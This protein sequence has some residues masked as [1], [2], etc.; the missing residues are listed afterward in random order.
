LDN[1]ATTRVADE[2][3]DAMHPFLTSLYGNPSSLHAF[4]AGVAKSIKKAR[5]QVAALLGV[6]DPS[7]IT[8]TSGGTEGDNLAIRGILEANPTKK[9]IVVTPVEH[10]AVLSLAAV[11]KKRGY[12]ITEVGVDSEGMLDLEELRG[13]IRPDTALVSVMYANNETGVIFPIKEVGEIVREKRSLLHVDAVQA[14]GKIPLDV[15]KIPVDL[16]VISGHKFHAPKGVGALF[17]RRGTRIH[18]QIIG[19]HQEKNRRGGT[20]NV[21]SIV[22]MGKAS[23]L[24]LAAL[25]EA[26]RVRGLR[27]RLE[28]GILKQCSTARLNGGR[29]LRLPNTLNIGFEGFEGE[30]LA[31]LLDHYG[32]CV[33]TGSACTSGSVDPS[34]VLR[35]M[36]LPPPL[37]QGAI[38]F[39]LSRYTTEAEIAYTLEKIPQA[40]ERLSSDGGK[41]KSDNWRASEGGGAY[42]SN[43]D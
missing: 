11:M 24:A 21:A 12:T 26:G 22:A 25:K 15:K 17:V 9:H 34:H 5:E 16:L 40:L 35:A 42:F 36:K 4:G 39:S 28:E 29:E 2:V 41:A 38:R 33:S 20:E 3:L 32:I 30:S 23:E 6:S 8:F 14:A 18:P 1:N 27:D 43:R 37:A 19:G 31:L 13:A 10:Q 7:E